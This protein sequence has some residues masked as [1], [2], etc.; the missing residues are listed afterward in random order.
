MPPP[1]EPIRFQPKN[2]MNHRNV[3]VSLVVLVGHWGRPCSLPRC[4][5]RTLSP[6]S[7]L[8]IPCPRLLK[9]RA[10]RKPRHHFFLLIH[11]FRL[12]MAP[13]SPTHALVWFSLRAIPCP[14]YVQLASSSVHS[15]G[16][17][18]ASLYAYTN[19][20]RSYLQIAGSTWSRHSGGSCSAA[21]RRP[22]GEKDPASGH[23]LT[24]PRHP[25]PRQ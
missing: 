5:T 19:T 21:R 12:L 20:H 6:A 15:E 22:F 3:N 10:L 4:R 8:A 13:V 7:V 16:T 23:R 9:H 18:V 24:R 1:G 17:R 14:R 25:E 2:A 11:L